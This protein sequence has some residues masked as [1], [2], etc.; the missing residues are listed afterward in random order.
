METTTFP[1]TKRAKLKLRNALDGINN[2]IT[3]KRLEERKG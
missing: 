3:G 2:I 1:G